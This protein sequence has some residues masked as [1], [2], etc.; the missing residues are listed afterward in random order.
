MCVNS[1]LWQKTPQ[2]PCFA[3][4]VMNRLWV[5]A[6][7]SFVCTWYYWCCSVVTTY[8][9]RPCCA[10]PIRNKWERGGRFFIFFILVIFPSLLF[11]VFPFPITSRSTET[12]KC[13]RGNFF[14]EKVARYRRERERERRIMWRER[15]EI[16]RDQ[17]T[18]LCVCLRS[19]T[20]QRSKRGPERETQKKWEAQE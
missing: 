16:W 14:D 19:H 12:P 15:K 4:R 17:R 6:S 10:G 20:G 5:L 8:R 7:F 13:S 18:V 9:I 3:A 1:R 11:A 2:S